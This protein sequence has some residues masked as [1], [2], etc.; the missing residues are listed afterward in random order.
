MN[1]VLMSISQVYF[2]Q[3]A[4]G[5]K[6]YEY[7]KKKCKKH[8]DRIIFYVGKPVC[9]VCGEA[10]VR[11]ALAGESGIIW[12][13]TRDGVGVS[14]E[15]IFTYCGE[16]KILYAYPILAFEQYKQICTLKMFGKKY[17][18]QSFYYYE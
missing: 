16:G 9:R 10:V 11:E 14:R 7:R 6:H 13:M 12:K 2:K 8:I 18:P 17:P 3:I 5:V 1:R 4:D 15:E